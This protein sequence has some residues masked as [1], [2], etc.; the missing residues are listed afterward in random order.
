MIRCGHSA[1]VPATC[2]GRPTRWWRSPPTTESRGTGAIDV[3]GQV[4]AD[5]YLYMLSGYSMF[6]R[7]PGNLLLAYRVRGA[8]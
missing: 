8:N 7:L 3:D 5:G 6:G 2:C 4:I 1:P